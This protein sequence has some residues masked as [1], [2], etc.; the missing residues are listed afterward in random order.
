M[1]RDQVEQIRIVMR[2]GLYAAMLHTRSGGP[3]KRVIGSQMIEYNL[4]IKEI[5]RRI[6]SLDQLIDS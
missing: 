3:I 1:T 4:T 2:L 5:Q 6:D